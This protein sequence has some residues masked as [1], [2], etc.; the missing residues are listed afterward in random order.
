MIDRYQLCI[1]TVLFIYQ[2]FND[3]ANLLFEAHYLRI[4]N[5]VPLYDSHGFVWAIYRRNFRLITYFHCSTLRPVNIKLH[6]VKTERIQ[7][8]TDGIISAA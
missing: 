6:I 5:S 3:A 7:A 8:H 4:K 1:C 2:K